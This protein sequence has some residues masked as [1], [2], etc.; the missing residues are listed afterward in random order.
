MFN[1]YGFIGMFIYGPTDI[2]LQGFIYIQRIY[3]D[4][5][6]PNYQPKP[7]KSN[8]FKQSRFLHL[9]FIMFSFHDILFVWEIPSLKPT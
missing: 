8:E 3:L 2:Q 6:E 5:L 7:A 4:L 9:D 1:G